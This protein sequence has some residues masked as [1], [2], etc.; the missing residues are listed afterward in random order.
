MKTTLFFILV[1]FFLQACKKDNLNSN[2]TIV[3]GEVRNKLTNELLAN[4]PIE[5]IGCD[6]NG[7]CLTRLKSVL[8]NI[9]GY[10]EVDVDQVEGYYRKKVILSNNDIIAPTQ[11]PYDNN[12][13]KNFET[14]VV[15]FYEKPIKLFQL[16]IKVLRHDKNWLQIGLTSNDNEGYYT[17]D[18]FTNFN[19]V[20]DLDTIYKRKIIAGRKYNVAVILA[21][22]INDN[23]QGVE[24]LNYPFEVF[25]VD[26]TFVN[27]IVQ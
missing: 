24:Y 18:F 5:I 4:M 1:L 19:P 9:N 16:K 27:V 7:K 13:V 8:T 2:K 11:Y 23:Y 20:Q 21:N 15:N 17:N 26:T 12:D 22:R 14:N 3:K 10:Y 25:N 6:F